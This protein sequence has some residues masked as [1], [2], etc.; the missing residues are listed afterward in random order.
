MKEKIASLEPSFVGTG[1][2]DVVGKGFVW[3]TVWVGCF[4]RGWVGGLEG[5]WVCVDMC[6]AEH[7]RVS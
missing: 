5:L 1:W 6:V 4:S 7:P 2:W 3:V